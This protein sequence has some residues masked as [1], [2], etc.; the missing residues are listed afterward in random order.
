MTLTGSFLICNK[1]RLSHIVLDSWAR[2]VCSPIM[3]LEQPDLN[4]CRRLNRLPSAKDNKK[5]CGQSH[6]VNITLESEPVSADRIY[7]T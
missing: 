2:A 1:R 7:D 5:I 4:Q 6:C 3:K